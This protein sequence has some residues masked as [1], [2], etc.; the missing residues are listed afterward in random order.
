MA[1]Y[2]LHLYCRDRNAAVVEFD[3]ASN[4]HAA[5][6][7]T[8]VFQSCTDA[9]D[10][11]EVR[12]EAYWVA[13]MS[14]L[15]IRRELRVEELSA[16]IQ[17]GVARTEELLLESKSRVALS[18]MLLERTRHCLRTAAPRRNGAKNTGF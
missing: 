4:S 1:T 17:E 2:H 15:G 9:A 5:A 18:K 3:A 14:K 13:G 7:G 6:V 16:Q 11:F 10:S 8:A 12:R